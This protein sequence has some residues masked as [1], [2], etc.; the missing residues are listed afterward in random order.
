MYSGVCPSSLLLLC[1]SYLSLLRMHV[2]YSI[3]IQLSV[4]KLSY[5]HPHRIHLLHP[6]PMRRGTSQTQILRSPLTPAVSPQDDQ[7]KGTHYAEQHDTTHLREEH[8]FNPSDHNSLLW[9]NFLILQDQELC[10]SSSQHT[11]TYTKMAISPPDLDLAT[12]TPNIKLG[13]LLSVFGLSALISSSYFSIF[14]KQS[15][16]CS[17]KS[18]SSHMKALASRPDRFT[19]RGNSSRY[20]LYRRLGGPQFRSGRC[21]E[22]K[23]CLLLPGI[24]PRLSSS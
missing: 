11:L 8:S 19:S 7:N 15:Q 1:P 21:G 24:E 22:E 23:N 3:I 2:P 5:V 18:C 17:C 14:C 6:V 16:S 4:V 20:P 12:H 10:S 13:N 9:P